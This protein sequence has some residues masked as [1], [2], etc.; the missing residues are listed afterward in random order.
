MML[1]T[2]GS[3]AL[4]SGCLARPQPPRTEALT[5]AEEIDD[6]VAQLYLL[7]AFGCLAALSGQPRRAAQLLGAADAVRTQAGANIM[8]FFAPLYS[9]ARES[10]IA[11]L[12]SARF[13]T[14]RDAA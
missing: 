14:K 9:K 7:D 5:L 1:L 11:G 10:A 6:W 4:L 8:P 12:G 2:Q 13:A 3:A